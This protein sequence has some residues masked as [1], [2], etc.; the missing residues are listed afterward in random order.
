MKK[1]GYFWGTVIVVAGIFLLLRNLGILQFNFWAIF[2]P[3]MLV[4]LGLWLVLGPVL[5]RNEQIELQKASVPLQGASTAFV[6][7]HHG[8][9]RLR[10]AAGD[11]PAEL[12][13]GNFYGGLRH[14]ERMNGG[15]L[16]VDM[17]TPE[18]T[19]FAIPWGFGTHGLDWDFV[20]NRDVLLKIKLETG[21]SENVI[22]LRDLRVTD[23]ELSTGASATDITLPANAGLTRLKVESGAASVVLRVPEGVAGRV[24]VSSGLASIKVNPARFNRLNDEYESADFATAAN[25]VEISIETGVGSVEVI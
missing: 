1:S 21:A 2:W 17:H 25:R 15:E 7:V 19:A 13:S 14:T 3:V 20:L 11:N 22:D 8:A 18:A 9:G 4:L 16:Q 24:K 12:L 6:R 10:I 5:F 23:V